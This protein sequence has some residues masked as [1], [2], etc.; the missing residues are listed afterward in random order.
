MHFQIIKDVMT[1]T[2][3]QIVLRYNCKLRLNTAS[4][5]LGVFGLA[6]F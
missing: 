5:K 3:E 4:W 2:K 1:A 6:I